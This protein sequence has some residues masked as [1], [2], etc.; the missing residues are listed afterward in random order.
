MGFLEDSGI[1][2]KKWYEVSIDDQ[3]KL[4][5][6]KILEKLNNILNDERI[7]ELN[8]NIKPTQDINE[9][10]DNTLYLI[11]KLLDWIEHLN[12]L[13][14]INLRLI[15]TVDQTV[16]LSDKLIDEIL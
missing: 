12:S 16:K 6:I 1:E 11:A 4:Q 10:I 9:C 13:K 3:D 14:E 15:N 5:D 2:N 8:L 7:K